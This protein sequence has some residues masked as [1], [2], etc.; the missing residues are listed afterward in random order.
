M[1]SS[2]SSSDTDANIPVVSS[3][4]NQNGG[5][6]DVIDNGGNQTE[7]SQADKTASKPVATSYGKGSSADQISAP[8]KVTSAKSAAQSAKSSRQNSLIPQLND[9]TSLSLLFGGLV[10][11]IGTVGVAKLYRKS[12]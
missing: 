5:D 1:P 6:G 10:L 9:T 12:K 8:A 11:L 4:N 3:N 2:S 7:M